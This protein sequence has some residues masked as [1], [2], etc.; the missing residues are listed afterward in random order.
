MKIVLRLRT[1]KLR[2]SKL[3]FRLVRCSYCNEPRIF[4]SFKAA[5]DFAKQQGHIEYKSSRIDLHKT[6]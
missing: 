2:G 4:K 6:R 3:A 5:K 1:G